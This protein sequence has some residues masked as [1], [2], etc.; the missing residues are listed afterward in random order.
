MY[1]PSPIS[2]NCKRFKITGVIGASTDRWTDGDSLL[3][4]HYAFNQ[5]IETGSCI[6]AYT[7]NKYLFVSDINSTID[8][9]L[10][11]R[12]DD[13]SNL[14]GDELS[15]FF[16]SVPYHGVLETLQFFTNDTMIEEAARIIAE[17][18]ADGVLDEIPEC[19]NLTSCWNKNPLSSIN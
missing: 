14:D 19:T 16:L 9:A 3:F 2:K 18:A 15:S 10:N 1:K 4:N 8:S 11:D 17:Y 13:L 12:F 7:P 6:S 5:T